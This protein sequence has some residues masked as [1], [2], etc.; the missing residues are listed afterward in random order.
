MGT[1]AAPTCPP[2]A[3][4]DQPH[5]ANP[6]PPP[7]DAG[8]RP[9]GLAPAPPPAVS[10]LGR[11]SR[12]IGG[13]SACRLL[14]LRGSRRARLPL[15]VAHSWVLLATLPQDRMR[16]GCPP[17]PPAQDPIPSEP[18]P[19]CPTAAGMRPKLLL[20]LQETVQRLFAPSL[21]WHTSED[22]YG[23]GAITR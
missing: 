13:Q 23:T 22:Q 5:G 20:L 6:D 21:P 12:V 15:A 18:E 14:E 1:A 2:D 7:T 10:G 4:G 8:D 17:R 16:D 19:K 3:A 11:P 9:H